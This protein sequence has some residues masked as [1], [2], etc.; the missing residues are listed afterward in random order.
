MLP[1]IANAEKYSAN[2]VILDEP[3]DDIGESIFD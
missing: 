2:S 3:L 1:K